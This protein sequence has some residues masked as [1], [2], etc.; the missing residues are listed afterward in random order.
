MQERLDQNQADQNEAV[1]VAE[2]EVPRPSPSLARRLSADIA[3][4]GGGFTGVSTAWHLR[5]RRPEL[6][7]VLLEAG[8]LGQGASGRNGGQVLH[9]VNGVTPRTP[10]ELRRIHAVTQIGIDLAAELAGRFAPAG[11]FHR[12]GALE[13][14]TDAQ[15]A[16]AAHRHVEALRAAGLPAEFLPGASLGMQGAR[17]AVLDPLAGRLN[18]FALLQSLRGVLAADG[19]AVHEHTPVRRVRTGAEIELETPGGSVRARALVL[20]T[21]GYTPSLGF[22]ARGILPLHSHV[23]ASAPLDDATWARIGWGAWDGFTDDLDR[24]A[25]ACRTPR[26]RLVF[27]GGGNAAYEYGFGGPTAVAARTGDRADRFLRGAMTRYFPALADVAVTHRW[28]GVLGITLDRVCSMGVGGKHR[29]VYHALGY[30]G[31]GVA[32]ALLAGRVLADL[33]EGN[34]DEWRDLPFYQKRLL[35]MPPE[36]LRWLGYQAYTRLTGRSPRRRS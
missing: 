8:V 11:T 3:I 19:V 10:D 4:V 32:L 31:H 7:I 36:P 27:G 26:G 6:G 17:G 29:N 9:W 28:A 14:Y 33:H 34:H 30:S 21:N 2:S 25:Y 13:I 18:G 35:P 5:R 23:L 22:F 12:R 16:E 15:R 20:A 24:I 1:W